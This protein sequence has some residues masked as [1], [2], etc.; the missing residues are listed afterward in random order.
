LS[1]SGDAEAD[2]ATAASLSGDGEAEEEL[3][4]ELLAELEIGL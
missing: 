2:P 3:A 4:G 1:E